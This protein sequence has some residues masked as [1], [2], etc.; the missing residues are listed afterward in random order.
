MPGE[1]SCHTVET[2]FWST[3]RNP[4]VMVQLDC[5]HVATLVAALACHAGEVQRNP[6]HLRLPATLMDNVRRGAEVVGGQGQ[7]AH[8][9]GRSAT[10]RSCPRTPIGLVVVQGW[11]E[12]ALA[13]RAGP[14]EH[15]AAATVS[16]RQF[17]VLIGL[18]SDAAA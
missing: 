6:Y 18:P 11:D 15:Q 10:R 3:T 4:N 1:F 2:E 13:T 5:E 14:A 8:R 17:F 9:R 16:R 12:A 7:A